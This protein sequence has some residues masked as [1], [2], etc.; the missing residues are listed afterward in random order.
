MQMQ[1]VWPPK[2]D[3]GLEIG[4]LHQVDLFSFGPKLKMVRL[5]GFSSKMLICWD[6]QPAKTNIF[7]HS[8]IAR[9]VAPR[10][11]FAQLTK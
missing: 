11:R 2:A 1:F 9:V 5:Q 8:I 4:L 6:G 7:G 3:L 10:V